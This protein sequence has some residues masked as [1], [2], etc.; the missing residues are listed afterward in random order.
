M[1]FLEQFQIFFWDLEPS[2]SQPEM[3]EW[4]QA[5]MQQNTRRD[6]NIKHLLLQ[7]CFLNQLRFYFVTSMVMIMRKV[8]F[9]TFNSQKEMKLR[10]SKV[11]SIILHAF[12]QK[13]W[14]LILLNRF[15]IALVANIRGEVGLKVTR[16]DLSAILPCAILY[17]LKLFKRRCLAEIFESEKFSAWDCFIT[18]INILHSTMVLNPLLTKFKSSNKYITIFKRCNSWECSVHLFRGPCLN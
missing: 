16:A 11:Y 17:L 3:T 10:I 7:S 9:S 1:Y 5:N 18:F 13:F 6:L 8:E 12:F 2:C 4:I 14:Y 15:W